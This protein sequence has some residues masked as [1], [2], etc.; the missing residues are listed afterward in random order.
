[1]FP[2]AR[3]YYQRLRKARV[4]AFEQQEQFAAEEQPIAVQELPQPET[5]VQR[6]SF[7]ATLVSMLIATLVLWLPLSF[8]LYPK[9]PL[10]GPL[11]VC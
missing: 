7:R 3:H 1:M 9:K 6:T 4:R 10:I 5:I 8:I 11:S 2:G